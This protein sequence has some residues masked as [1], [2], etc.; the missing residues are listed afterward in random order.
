VQKREDQNQLQSSTDFTNTHIQNQFQ[1][2]DIKST[3]IRG[4]YLDFEQTTKN[5]CITPAHV[6]YFNV[7]P[8]INIKKA[9]QYNTCE[10]IGNFK[11]YTCLERKIKYLS[12]EFDVNEFLQ[13]LRMIKYKFL[14]SHK[15]EIQTS[16]TRKIFS[17]SEGI[18]KS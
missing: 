14:F 13:E 10:L 1:R 11:Q 4:G 9:F 2:I 15:F 12:R 7:L 5:A 8:Y 3:L 17:C 6:E 16:K 18:F